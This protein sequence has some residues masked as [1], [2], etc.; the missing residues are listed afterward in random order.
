MKEKLYTNIQETFWKIV[1]KTNI[2]IKKYLLNME[3][4]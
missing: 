1:V 4:K 3:E 2:V